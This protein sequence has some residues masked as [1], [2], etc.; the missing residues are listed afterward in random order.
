MMTSLPGGRAAFK[1]A[2]FGF[3][4]L[5]AAIVPAS[6]R[7][8]RVVEESFPVAPGG[9]VRVTT[10]G[11]DI[12]VTT[13]DESVVHVRARQVFRGADTDAE[14][15]E[16]LEKLE[17]VL[18]A[19]GNDVVAKARY[20]GERGVWGWFGSRGNPVQVSFEVVVPAD[21]RANLATSGG[22]IIVTALDGSAEVRTS[23]GDIRLGDINGEVKAS[24]SGGDIVIERGG[25][26][27]SASTSGGDIK[28]VEAA[29]DVRASTSGGDVRVE[30]VTGNIN[31]STSGGDVYA[32]IAGQFTEDISLGTSGGDV[33]AVIDED[34]GLDL[35]ASTSGGEVSAQG[36]TIRIDSGNPKRGKLRGEVN[37]GG[38][39]LRLRSSGGD[40]RIRIS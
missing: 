29:G 27:V 11:G 8:V 26:R 33:T 12:R 20:E 4:A 7:I 22:D 35:D 23:G 18:E 9:E 1:S 30:R 14:A 31:A 36:L 16:I 6:A 28:I 3:V 13:G 37:G 34:I 2:L 19:A 32:R 21:Y 5:G 24:T 17:F 38:P 10:S 15:D 25:G 39:Q 40:I